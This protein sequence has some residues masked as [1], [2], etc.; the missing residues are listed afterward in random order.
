MNKSALIAE[1][2]IRLGSPSDSEVTDSAIGYAIDSALSELSKLQPYYVYGEITLSKNMSNYDI[3]ND[4]IDIKRFWNS[5]ESKHPI[6][7]Q[8]IYITGH[9]AVNYS[10][11][12]HEYTGI[13]TF[14]SPSLINIIEEKWERLRSRK[15]FSW[16]FNP[17]TNQLMVLPTPHANG[18][19]VYKG[20]L[21]RD[22]STVGTKYAEPFKDLVKVYSMET[23]LFKTSML[24]SI[25]VGVGKVD[26]ETKNSVDMLRRLKA[27][28][29]SKLKSGG[30]AVVIG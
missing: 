6:N 23:W 26:Y 21:M 3:D 8:D 1:M 10:P 20:T 24:K 5:L 9:E 30:S 19:G 17:D 7:L 28:A 13:K 4:V 29:L 11:H 16:E 14:H 27:D 22:L 18:I 12:G 15:L 2:R 25:P